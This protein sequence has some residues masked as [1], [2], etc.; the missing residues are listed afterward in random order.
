MKL[1]KI[2]KIVN[3]HGIKGE[4]RI[5]SK[6]PYKDKVFVKNMKVY[7]DKNNIEV[8]NTYR[9]HKNFDMVTFE[10]YNNINE[11]IIERKNYRNGEI[12]QKPILPDVKQYT[13]K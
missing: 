12:Y 9:K 4:L 13:K 11:T 6:F 3:T 2:G 1:I 10:G 8:I 7:I 5:L